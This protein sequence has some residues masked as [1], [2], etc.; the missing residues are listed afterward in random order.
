M[1]SNKKILIFAILI[2]L[3]TVFGV[4]HYIN[5]MTN[6]EETQIPYSQVV[7]ALNNI[8]ANVKVTSEMVAVKSIP[9]ESIHPE[10]IIAVDKVIGVT[11][12]AEIVKGE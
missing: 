1:K 11:S 8:P 2:G 7:V 6:I 12:N 10:A 3:I 9:T 4:R 5:K